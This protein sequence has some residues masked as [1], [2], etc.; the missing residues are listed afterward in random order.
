MNI[1][2]HSSKSALESRKLNFQDSYSCPVCRYGHISVLTLTEAFACDFCR[3]IFTANLE[4]QVL[5]MAD[6]TPPMAWRWNGKNWKIAH[7]KDLELSFV[8]WLLGIALVVFPTLIV[9]VSSYIFPPEEGSYQSSFPIFWLFLTFFSHLTLVI[10]LLA[11]SF[12]LPFY[13][14]LKVKIRN[15]LNG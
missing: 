7:Q 13:T 1:L 4:E 5:I 12:Q 14:Y 9:G 2:K 15:L 11:E 8:V 10:W 6:S 3:H